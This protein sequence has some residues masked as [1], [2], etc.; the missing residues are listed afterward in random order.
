KGNGLSVSDVDGNAGSETITLAVTEGTLSATVGDSGVTIVSGNG[1]ASLQI[2]GTITELNAL[3][4]SGG[5]STLAYVH[6]AAPPSPSAPPIPAIADNG[7]TGR[8]NLFSL[9]T[10]TTNIVLPPVLSNAGSTVGF[11]EGG[12]PVF[13]EGT[14][15]GSPTGIVVSDADAPASGPQINSATV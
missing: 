2:S 8:G 12:S 9:D 1:T 4:G 11:T 5:T 6:N 10:A 13:L 3:L 7:N 14:G 15:E